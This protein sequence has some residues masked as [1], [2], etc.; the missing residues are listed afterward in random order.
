MGDYIC[1]RSGKF[2]YQNIGNVKNVDYEI[3]MDP[4]TV[5][6]NGL[7]KEHGGSGVPISRDKYMESVKFWE[8]NVIVK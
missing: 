7:G 2:N 6:R 4:I 8:N 1:K 5:M 3:P